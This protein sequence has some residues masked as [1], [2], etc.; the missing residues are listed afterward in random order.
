MTHSNKTSAKVTKAVAHAVQ[1]VSAGLRK[2]IKRKTVKW[3]SVEDFLK[4]YHWYKFNREKGTDMERVADIAYDIAFNNTGWM[5]PP[6]IVNAK[7]KTALDGNTSGQGQVMAYQK[8]GVDLEIMVVEVELPEGM[9]D[10]Q[11][12]HILNDLRKN[13]RLRDYIGS[14][15]QQKKADFLRL[16][17][18]ALL[19]GECFVS[20]TGEAQW[21]YTLAL[22]GSSQ[23]EQR[24]KEDRFVFTKGDQEQCFEVG[25]EIVKVW[26]MVGSP[27]TGG[28]FEAFIFAWVNVRN[29]FGK[30]FKLDKLY[31]FFSTDNGRRMFDGSE[32]TRV[33][34]DRL[35]GILTA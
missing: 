12:V 19:L 25:S 11:A 28:W 24:I 7:T 22:S 34:V 18:L 3:V 21:R 27:K 1:Q 26:K 6:V 16:Q 17:E 2:L 10:H 32:N 29:I 9:T 4:E 35:N 14:C 33:W 15:L 20:S 5:L 13:W 30:N 23:Q 31:R 8:Y